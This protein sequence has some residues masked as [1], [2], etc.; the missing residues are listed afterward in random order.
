MKY[1][2]FDIIEDKIY[3]ETGENVFDRLY[4]QRAT[5]PTQV[6]INELIKEK[7]IKVTQIINYFNKHTILDLKKDISKLNYVIPLYDEYSKNMYLIHRDNVYSRVIYRSYRFPDQD[8]IDI[9]KNKIKKI[10]PIVSEINKK[11]KKNALHPQAFLIRELRK[12]KL[13][14]SFLDS[15]DFDTLKN[16]YI[17]AFYFFSNEVGKDITICKKPSFLPHFTHI[18]PYYT[19]SE[20]I[21]MALNMKKIKPNN[22]Y[23]T[24]ESITSLCTIVKDN[25]INA[26]ILLK[27][28]KYI[29]NNTKVGIIQYYSLQGSYF[30]NKYLRN[31]DDNN[32]KNIILEKSIKSMYDLINNS[33]AFDK[34]YILYRF[35]KDDAH[36]KHLDIG[37][38]YVDPSFISTTRDPFYMSDIYKFGF[39]LIKIKIPKK[40]TGVGLCIETISH[41]PEEQEILL[42]PFSILQLNKKDEN[43][44]YYH[45]DK[46]TQTKISTR[47]EF[48][49]I[50]KQKLHLEDKL[51]DKPNKLVD[52]LKIKKSDSITVNERIRYFI[53][54][55]SNFIYQVDTLIS[56]TKFT[57][58]LEWYNSTK[59]YDKYYAATNN[60][61]F[62]IYS[63]VDDHVLFTIELGEDSDKVY[64]YVN[65]YFRYSTSIRSDKISDEDFIEFLSKIA[66]YFEIRYV[67][68]YSDYGACDIKDKLILD[69]TI[70]GNYSTDFY[71]Y[72][73]FKKKK[74]NN[75]NITSSFSYESLD[76]LKTINPT[77]VLIKD[78]Q[79][80]IY[81]IYMKTYVDLCESKKHNIADF[82]IY[83][84]E[85]NCA[86]VPTFVS[87]LVRLETV[88][89][90]FEFDYY[91]LDAVSYLYDRQLIDTLETFNQ[92]KTSIEDIKIKTELPKNR[93][94]LLNKTRS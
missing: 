76:K 68:L 79:D 56:K 15:F 7:D 83:L 72:L 29:I 36:L 77:L 21:N 40:V 44:E 91:I 74:Y 17:N 93:Y 88:T 84:V 78:D 23:Y 60:N 22:K 27:H 2:L 25:D 67:I 51:K 41:F 35:V 19:R 52:F 66:Y 59:V 94:R 50:G 85:N 11:S 1:P 47:Y 37:D 46:I 39:I 9:F 45:T 65:Y 16:T 89:N 12:L 8:M 14:L 71:N 53:N 5:I 26:D 81:Y 6:Q 82:Y 70:G 18:T 61:G 10:T 48:T 90:P 4:F 38:K 92:S 55:Y 31:L 32:F 63:I 24:E 87:K 49:Y 28:Q 86:Y 42:S 73:K 33:P 34:N 3:L 80:E 54:E 13:M 43:A 58:I 57:L 30:I 69:N 20:L 64:M 62:I 75:K